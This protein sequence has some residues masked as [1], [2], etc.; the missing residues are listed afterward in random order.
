MSS[1]NLLDT[2]LEPGT[3]KVKVSTTSVSRESLYLTVGT[4]SD[5]PWQKGKCNSFNL[6]SMVR[7]VSDWITSQSATPLNTHWEWGPNIQTLGEQQHLG[8]S[9]NSSHGSVPV[10]D[11]QSSQ[12]QRDRPLTHFPDKRNTGTTG[13][14]TRPKLWSAAQM[15]TS[16]TMWYTI[17]LK[18]VSLVDDTV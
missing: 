9:M 14:Y 1:G 4:F 7:S 2:V 3:S 16:Y 12:K 11:P 6:H 8:Q 13:W 18:G 10:L 15:C 5:L 17:L